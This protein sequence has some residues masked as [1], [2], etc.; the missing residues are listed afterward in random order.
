MRF[1]QIEYTWIELNPHFRRPK[2]MCAHFNYRKIITYS[3]F[4][5]VSVSRQMFIVFSRQ[6]A[7]FIIVIFYLLFSVCWKSYLLYCWSLAYC[8]ESKNIWE[9][10]SESFKKRFQNRVIR[11]NNG[12]I[13]RF[14]FSKKIDGLYCVEDHT[15]KCSRA[16]LDNVSS[17]MS[18][19]IFSISSSER[20][21]LTPT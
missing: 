11:K 6:S 9:F 20:S 2:Q 15:Q 5:F 10:S 4:L 14:D 8:R 19:W 7:I 1:Q 18:W 21:R 3:S 12:A 13:A 17:I 16:Q